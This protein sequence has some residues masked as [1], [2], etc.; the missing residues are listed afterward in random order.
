MIAPFSQPRT[1]LKKG[2]II[3]CHL[4]NAVYTYAWGANPGLQ[5]IITGLIY[6]YPW[7]KI[8]FKLI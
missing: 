1:A 8:L 4:V 7:A 5:N 2:A 3:V 6:G